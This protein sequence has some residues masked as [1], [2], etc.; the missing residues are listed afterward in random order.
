MHKDKRTEFI[1]ILKVVVQY[2]VLKVFVNCPFRSSIGKILYGT[3]FHCKTYYTEVQY[4]LIKLMIES[5]S[6]STMDL[7]AHFVWGFKESVSTVMV[8]IL[9]SGPLGIKLG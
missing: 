2:F 6:Q 7:L 4:S 3:N 1:T 9:V 5:R 8:S